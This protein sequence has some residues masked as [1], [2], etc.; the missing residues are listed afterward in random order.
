MYK[1]EAGGMLSMDEL[2]QLPESF[3]QLTSQRRKPRNL[4]L[5][6]AALSQGEFVSTLELNSSSWRTN[7]TLVSEE[8]DEHRRQLDQLPHLL[9]HRIIRGV[10]ATGDLIQAGELEASV[11]LTETKLRIKADTTSDS[12][13]LQS[14]PSWKKRMLSLLQNHSSGAG[15]AEGILVFMLVNVFCGFVT[16]GMCFLYRARKGMGFEGMQDDDEDDEP[17]IRVPRGDH[18]HHQISRTTQDSNVAASMRQPKPVTAGT[19][20][21]SF[22]TSS[23]PHS[24]HT[25]PHAVSHTVPHTAESHHQPRQS[26]RQ[27]EPPISVRRQ[28]CPELVVPR[29]SECVL[30]VRT[31]VSGRLQQVEFDILD[32]N[33][34]PVLRVEV[35]PQF[36]A[37][38]RPWP[39][40]LQRSPTIALKSLNARESTGGFT[41]CYCCNVIK[42]DEGSGSK[43]NVYIYKDDDELFA[44]LMKD[45]I[46]KRYV[47]TSGRLGLQLLFEGNFEEHAVDVTNEARELLAATEPGVMEFDPLNKYYKLRVAADV[48]VGLVLCGL[49]AI[50]QMEVP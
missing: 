16:V 35:S 14:E 44:H 17:P 4:T 46:R 19:W 20:S 28:L 32:V 15:L 27:S 36:G 34:K 12:V 9:S 50:D 1:I 26:D 45:E 37:H 38:S 11:S 49:L 10:S 6:L 25:G 39:A 40:Q 29:G 18:G 23:G 22:P 2:R 47:L 41:L 43:R 31:V 30:A 33:G 42:E 5:A 7:L 24:F 21:P 13:T 8:E 48:D 3:L